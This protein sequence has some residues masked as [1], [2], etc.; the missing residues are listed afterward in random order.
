MKG[1]FNGAD[2]IGDLLYINLLIRHEGY[3]GPDFCSLLFKGDPSELKGLKKGEDIEVI[4]E[5][6]DPVRIERLPLGSVVF[7]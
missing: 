5:N 3:R 2:K 6:G 7:E 4:F 1:K